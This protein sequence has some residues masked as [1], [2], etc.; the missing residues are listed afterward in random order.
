MADR[1][2]LRAL[3]D[4]LPEGALESAQA[5]LKA[6]QIWPPKEPEYPPEVRSTGKNWKRSEISLL[7]DMQAERGP[8]TEKTRVTP[9]SVRAN[10]TG[11][12]AN[13]L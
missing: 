2:H 1:E 12:R 11:K 3:V 6:I 13:T 4:S 9:R 8:S 7:K 5:Y 10:I